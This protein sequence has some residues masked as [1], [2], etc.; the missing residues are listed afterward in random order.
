M[1]MLTALYIGTDHVELKGQTCIIVQIDNDNGLYGCQFDD[2][3]LGTWAGG[4]NWLPQSD[5]HLT[6]IN[7]WFEL[8]YASWLTIPR[9]LLED[10]PG[11]WQVQ[12]T[13]L[14]QEYAERYPKQ[15]HIGTQ[16]RV[17]DMRNRLTP[18]PK[19]ITNY[20]RPDQSMIQSIR[21]C[22]NE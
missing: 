9:V 13:K 8:S 2:M 21:G 15:P 19:W 3:E 22:D 11:S 4:C 18:T 12:F 7:D 14:L 10:M 16:V 5:L 6:T 20:K 1:K 17:T